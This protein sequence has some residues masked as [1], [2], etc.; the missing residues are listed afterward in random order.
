MVRRK[1]ILGPPIGPE[2]KPSQ[3]DVVVPALLGDGVLA[4]RVV[5]QGEPPAS[6]IFVNCREL[7]V[8]ADR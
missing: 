4:S 6:S 8:M 5:V 1:R 7:R 2:Q 3:R